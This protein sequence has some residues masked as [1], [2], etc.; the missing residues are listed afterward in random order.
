M[1]E[2]VPVSDAAPARAPRKVKVWDIV[3]SII[4]LVV[5]IGGWLVGIVLSVFGTVL[6]AGDCIDPSCDPGNNQYLQASYIVAPSILGVG[7]VIVVVRLALKRVAWPFALAAG[8][9]SA[10]ALFGGLWP[11]TPD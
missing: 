11:S 2:T 1:T 8:I 10:A 7:I 6:L 3:L 5:G 9:L 4:L